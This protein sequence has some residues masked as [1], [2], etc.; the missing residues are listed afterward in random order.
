MAAAD[1]E[2]TVS[3]AVASQASADSEA[4][5]Q[6]PTARTQRYIRVSAL[7]GHMC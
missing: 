3:E 2:A 6:E 4:V 7:H 1:A 5:E